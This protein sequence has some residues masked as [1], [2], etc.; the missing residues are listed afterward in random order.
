MA[1]Q[2]T[3]E[4]L[5]RRGRPRSE[6]SRRAILRAAS[7]LLLEHG[8]SSISMDAVAER[9]RA[10]KATIYRWWPSKELLTLDAIFSE[11]ATLAPERCD[12]GSLTGDLHALM[13]PWARAISARPYA[14]VI[15]ALLAKVQSD[16]DFGREYHARLVRP[17]RAHAAT[18]FAM[19][20]ERGEIAPDTDIEAALDLLYGP[21]YLRLL[22]G[23]AALDDRFT[24]TTV[25]HVVAALTRPLT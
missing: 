13:L 9:A 14:R 17:R 21:F 4:H 24:H 12:T 10:S 1:T 6:S 15:A 7:E 22:Q 19:A 8:L 11:W 25:D 20:I 5:R 2:G 3:I 18:V 23:H 16:P